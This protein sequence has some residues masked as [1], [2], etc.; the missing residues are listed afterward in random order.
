MNRIKFRLPALAC[1]ALLT[2]SGVVAVVAAPRSVESQ[3]SLAPVSSQPAATARIDKAPTNIQ[4]LL[5]AAAAATHSEVGDLLAVEGARAR[6]R[7]EALALIQAVQL[8][9]VG[10]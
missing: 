7:A 10:L 4:P 2:I 8:D 5:L 1:G 9:L 3:N 6:V